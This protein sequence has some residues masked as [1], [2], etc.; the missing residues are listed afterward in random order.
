M[1]NPALLRISADDANVQSSD[2]IEKLESSTIQIDGFRLQITQ[3]T[4]DKEEAV[5]ETDR[6]TKRVNELEY[7]LN[8]RAT[9][10]ARALGI[11]KPVPNLHPKN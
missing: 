5:N 2:L 6:L 4:H 7:Q 11:L 8:T 3:L 1:K 9:E 10:L